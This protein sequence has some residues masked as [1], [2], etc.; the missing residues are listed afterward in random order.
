MEMKKKSLIYVLAIIWLLNCFLYCNKFLLAQTSEENLPLKYKKWLT[1]D[2]VYI[3]TQPE[4]ELFLSLKTDEQR[5]SFID[6]FWRRRDT[7]PETVK[8]E[9]KEEHYSRIKYANEKLADDTPR[10]GWRTERGRI[11]ILLGKPDDIYNKVS[12][13]ILYPIQVWDYRNVK[14]PGFPSSLRLMFFKR[15]GVGEF[16][17]YNPI[18]DGLQSILTPANQRFANNPNLLPHIDV[19][20][21]QAAYSIAPGY[22]P[23]TSQDV[24]SELML[25][26][27]I[28]TPLA[29]RN[30]KE[31]V[32]A[33]VT[34]VTMPIDVLHSYWKN[35]DT[36]SYL[37]YVIEVPP[38]Y[39]TFKEIEDKFV[40]RLDIYG[41][42]L[43]KDQIVAEISKEVNIE[44]TKMELDNCKDYY[45]NFLDR[46]LL[47]PGEYQLKLFI[48]NYISNEIGRT[49]ESFIIP[50]I[51]R[52]KLNLSSVVWA[53]K[54]EEAAGG[55]LSE[56]RPFIF[57]KSVIYPKVDG[58]F[59][60]GQSF[61]VYYEIYYPAHIESSINPSLD[62]TYS[63]IKEGVITKT[64]KDYL[65]SVSLKTGNSIPIL[66]TFSTVGLEPGEYTL[67]VEAKDKNLA[68]Y[69]SGEADFTLSNVAQNLG[70]FRFE[71]SLPEKSAHRHYELGRQYYIQKLY[72]KAKVQ[73]RIALDFNPNSVPATVS[74]AK[75]Y[76]FEKNYKEAL[77]LLNKAVKNKPYDYDILTAMAACHAALNQY[78]EAIQNYKTLI[79]IG[80]SS[81]DVYNALGVAY[82]KENNVKEAIKAFQ[83]SLKIKA[84]Q[85]DV[86]K[87]L[88]A[89]RKNEKQK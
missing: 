55:K 36:T 50:P 70:R 83:S 86:E 45:F 34:Y 44:L 69:V 23:Q 82:I 12:S 40:A 68:M 5:N 19:E 31:V 42:I 13:N 59:T 53:Y 75:C 9:F 39:L 49:E 18:F 33:K 80:Y 72:D 4:K 79:E 89:L 24:I 61:F 62:I 47:I 22:S 73:F 48:R 46:K 11:H 14:M 29:K 64:D 25:P 71:N 2:V 57:G 37:D 65:S 15:F 54:L 58:T 84:N 63:L 41:S 85:P 74:L 60:A 30:L 88:A 52:D 3:I 38:K 21:R 26:S 51:S 7:V 43:S 20:I 17:L 77:D 76:V 81:V 6:D 10:E 1:E 66:K 8:N 67:R 28:I 32:K 56:G 87:I 16:R 27:R 35:D 78:Q